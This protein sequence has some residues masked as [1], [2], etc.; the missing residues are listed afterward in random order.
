VLTLR[1][2]AGFLAVT[3]VA[4]AATAGSAMADVYT[5]TGTP[6]GNA[7]AV[8]DRAGN[9]TLTPAGTVLTGGTGVPAGGQGALALEGNRLVAVNAGSS[10][11]SLFKIDGQGPGLR[12]V[13]PSGGVSPLSATIHGRLV[14]VLN[15]GGAANNIT[16]FFVWH[17]R[18]V[19]LPGSTRPLSAA[20]PGPA[21]VQFSPDGRTLVVTEKSTNRIDTYAVGVDGIP[22]GPTVSASAGGTP[23]GFAFDKRGRIFV[24]EATLGD[25]SSYSI[26]DDGSVS[27]ISAT[28]IDHQAAPCWVAVSEDGKYAYTANAGSSSL[29]GY[30][31]AK[32]GAISLLNASG[33]SA[34]T[35]A[36]PVD[37]AFA[38]G[39]RFLYALAN[40]AGTIDAYRVNGNGSLTALGSAGGLA[41]NGTGLVAN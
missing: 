34:S 4:L 1:Q 38:D 11:V 9:G 36:H 32:N 41:A 23:F 16:G 37:L 19:P 26:A 15:S 20:A 30:A 2:L 24:S 40:G 7:V 21:Q 39:S 12:D 6:S 33:V 18:L 29:S 28:V 5:L 10:T 27:P 14:Y 13:E 17:N 22:T 31:I 35:D 3:A 8:F 25:V